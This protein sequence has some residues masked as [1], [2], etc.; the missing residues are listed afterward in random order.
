LGE[1]QFLRRL[2]KTA[3]ARGG[4]EAS[5]GIQGWPVFEHD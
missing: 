5:Q 2:V 4:F 3:Q 1:V